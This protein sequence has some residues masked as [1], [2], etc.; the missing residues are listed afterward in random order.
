M[1]IKKI[2]IYIFRWQKD[3]KLTGWES[4]NLLPYVR[5]ALC[6]PNEAASVSIKTVNYF[7]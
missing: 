2:I 7:Y 4:D 6:G 3:N 5:R 1:N